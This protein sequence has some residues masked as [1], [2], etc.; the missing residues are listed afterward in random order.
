MSSHSSRSSRVRTKVVALLASLAALWG[1]AAYVTLRD[2]TNLLSL[3]MLAAEVGKPSEDM[4]A[5]LQK[6]RRASL[7]FLADSSPANR[8]ALDSQRKLTDQTVATYSANVAETGVRWVAD[9]ALE[10]R[11]D[12]VS[13][14]LGDLAQSR[15]SIDSGAMDR[16]RAAAWYTEVIDVTFHMYGSLVKLDDEEVSKRGRALVSL[17]RATEL[18]SQEDA[19]VAGAL[20]AAQL[21]PAEHTQFVQLV[22]TQRYLYDQAIADLPA[23]D[24][25]RYQEL[26][27][28]QAYRQFSALEDRISAAQAA[29][30]P[31]PLT[32]AE[33]ELAIG[34][35]L[36]EQRD[37]ILQATDHGLELARPMAVGVIVRLILAGGLG[38][39]A[40]IASIVD[41]HHHRPQPG[42]AV[43][44]A[45]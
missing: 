39:L 29:G 15:A 25:A 6:E 38:L 7:V 27:D 32:A 23:E 8:A 42:Q 3:T 43:G 31:P 34:P 37:A 24:Q 4:V 40:V 30:T 33:W 28:S 45:A 13:T 16:T 20:T 10:Q 18:L 41:F 5:N 22:G 19:L 26:A 17:S 44:A 1:F 2:G 35:M 12:D 14:Q 11:F 21:S 9:D 36:A